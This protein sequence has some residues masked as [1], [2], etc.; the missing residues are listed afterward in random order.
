MTV[1]VAIWHDPHT[2][3][4]IYVFRS[5]LSASLAIAARMATYTLRDGEE[6]TDT[7]ENPDRTRTVQ[8]ENGNIW[9]EVRCCEV[10]L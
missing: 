6:W 3:D 1:Y 5:Y 9:G 10:T 7:G 2:D 4:E 8:S